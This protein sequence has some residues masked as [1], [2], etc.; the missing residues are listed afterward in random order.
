MADRSTRMTC[1][2]GNAT[3][4]AQID[5]DSLVGQYHGDVY[6]Y[7]YRLSGNQSDAEDLAQQT[8]LIAHQRLD[9]LRDPDKAA[10]W[11][12]AILRSCHL[13]SQRRRRPVAAA[14]L[15]LDVE[16]IPDMLPEEEIDSDLLQLAID[17]L[18]DDNK[19]VLVMFYFEE[20]SYKEIAAKLSIPIGT[21]MSRLARAKNRLRGRLFQAEGSQQDTPARRSP[22]DASS[23]SAQ[24]AG[25]R[26]RRVGR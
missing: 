21:V 8:F 6:R 22:T 9:Q 4:R 14:S 12:F 20:C 16:A 7:A 17:E 24:A 5:L 10:A 15:E 18:P 11:L 2:T 25:T 26:G 13:K 23:G 1:D 19:L 3:G